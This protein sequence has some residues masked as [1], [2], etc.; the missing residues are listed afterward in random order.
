M[1]KEESHCPPKKDKDCCVA[2]QTQ[3]LR[4]DYDVTFSVD[5][6]ECN[7]IEVTVVDEEILNE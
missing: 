6:E 1:Y 2:D 5:I 3:F 4:V 7:I